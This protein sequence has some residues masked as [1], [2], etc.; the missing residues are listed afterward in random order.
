M[1]NKQN[2]LDIGFVHSIVLCPT[3]ILSREQKTIELDLLFSAKH[4]EFRIITQRNLSCYIR[5]FR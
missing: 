4:N 5:L 3:Y 1:I 2:G